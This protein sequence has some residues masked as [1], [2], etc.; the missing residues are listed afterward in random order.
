MK[1]SKI[2]STKPQE[3][4]IYRSGRGNVTLR[5]DI[6]KE[7]IWAT[8][9]QIAELFD[10]NVPTVHEHIK[11]IYKTNELSDKATIRNFRIVQNEGKR[12]VER[13]INHY[14]LDVVIAVGYRVNSKQATQFRI[15]ATETLHDYIMH[16]VAVNTERISKLH[17]KGIL[18]LTKKISFI[19]DTIRRRQ[20]IK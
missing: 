13:D 3:I 10:V 14:N 17:E 1:K 5:A 20:L 4:V 16:G 15:W 6:G 7:T 9:A 11:N 12:S 8:Q 19:Q 2:I 18:D